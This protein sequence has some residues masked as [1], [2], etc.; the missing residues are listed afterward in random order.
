MN[1]LAL[2]LQDPLLIL[3]GFVVGAFGT[4]VG[5]GGG[6]ILVP[7]LLFLYPEKEP[8]TIT[9]ISLF[10]VFANATS[11]SLAYGYQRRIDFRSGI[12]FALATL[13]GALAGAFVVSLIPRRAFDGMFAAALASIGLFLL[14]RG[15]SNAIQPPV[16]GWSTVRRTFVDRAGNRY[17]YSF[18]MWKGVAISAGIG[19]VSSLL[20]IGGGVMHVPVMATVLH[21]PV[22]IAAATSQFVLAFMALEG[23]SVHFARG[24]LTFDRS[25]AQAAFLAIG[26]VGGA[27]AGALLSR[28]IH[29]GYILRVLAVGLILVAARLALKAAAG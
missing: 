26:A 24:V 7:V 10:V 22:H 4:L 12:P 28:R 19:F 5:A 16:Q 11:G 20:G 1:G 25:L 18:Q 15:A 6:F 14:V 9:A 13:P 29:G 21:F 2:E 8:E 3:L 27:Q 17:F 23:S